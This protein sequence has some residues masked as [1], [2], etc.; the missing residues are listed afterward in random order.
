M[1]IYSDESGGIDRDHFVAAMV[2][3]APRQ[4]KEAAKAC[5][6]IAR[7]GDG[8]VKGT[9]LAPEQR[10]RCWDLILDRQAIAVVSIWRRDTALGG[11]AKTTM[12]ELPL[13]TEMQFEACSLLLRSGHVTGSPTLTVDS[14]RYVHKHLDRSMAELQARL[15]AAHPLAARLRVE[16]RLSHDVPGLLVADIIANTVWRSLQPE[17]G[18]DADRDLVATAVRRQQLTLVDLRL[19]G[20]APAWLAMPERQTV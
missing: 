4:A 8:E 6:K 12:K 7:A 20:R 5:R 3:M 15:V 19:E 14:G 17:D 10:T 2:L 16:T 1:Q 18:H 9:G 13:R 11:W